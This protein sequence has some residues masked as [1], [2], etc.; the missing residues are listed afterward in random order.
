MKTNR[1]ITQWAL[2][3][4]V[5]GLMVCAGCGQGVAAPESYRPQ[6]FLTLPNWA[7]QPDGATLDD[8]TGEMFLSIP[9]FTLTHEGT[10]TPVYPGCL[11][12]ICKKN[13]AWVFCVLPQHP[14]TGHA[15]PMGLDIGADNNIYVA[16][17]QYFY[18]KEYASRVIRVVRKNGKA[19]ATEI[20][21]DGLKLANAVIWRG[22]A[23]YV[24]DTFLDIPDKPNTS[25][26]FRI[27]LEEM[28][29]GT[30]H[31]KPGLDD[32]HLIATFTTI[33]NHR[34]DGA[35]ADGLTFDA[36]GNLYC[37]NF[38]DGVI[39]KITFDKAGKVTSNKIILKSAGL[40]SADGMFWDAK[41]NMIYIADSEKNAIRY[42]STDGK[43]LKTLWENGDTTGADG[44]T[45]QPCEVII[46][47]DE[48]IIVDFDMPF[49]GL[50]NQKFDS[51][52][53]LHVIKLDPNR[54]K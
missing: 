46:R 36:E 16:D 32:P 23:M 20:A 53:G 15:G 28:A 25:G 35:G 37:G 48:L 33:P 4:V 21:V 22:N 50:I 38:G 12:R 39:S 43:T 54:G 17:N 44:L 8:R 9:N 49:P 29:K 52:H 1:A 18:D 26:V 7:N 13:K 47:G 3:A 51:W 42:F 34:K 5:T 40:T 41:S 30:V 24:S 19:A 27:T 6:N 14:K 10:D 11:M 2:L 31:I 45:D